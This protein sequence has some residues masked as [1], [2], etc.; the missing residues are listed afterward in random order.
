MNPLLLILIQAGFNIG[1]AHAGSE[2]GNVIKTTG[3]LIDA[4]RAIDELYEKEAGQPLD[5]TSLRHHGH[6]PPAGEEVDSQEGE[7]LEADLAAG[8]DDHNPNPDDPD[9]S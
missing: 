1:A 5:W 7:S 9:E 6:L 4:A 2:V 3:F 8:P